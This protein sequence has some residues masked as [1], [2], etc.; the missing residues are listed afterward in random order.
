MQKNLPLI[1][2]ENG[3]IGVNFFGFKASAGLGSLLTG[4]PA[5]GGIHAEAETPFG[6]KA[7][8]GI[9]TDLDENGNS[10][11]SYSYSSKGR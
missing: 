9:S 4:N 2:F 8:A 6:Q 11:G 1:Y 5:D 10:R 3:T 7:G